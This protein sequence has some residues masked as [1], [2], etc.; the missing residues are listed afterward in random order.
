MPTYIANFAETWLD[1]ALDD[2]TAS[3]FAKLRDG[4]L[5][6]LA[7]DTALNELRDATRARLGYDS[8]DGLGW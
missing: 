2:T 5:S 8:E 6:P 1:T 3:L 4:T 7:R